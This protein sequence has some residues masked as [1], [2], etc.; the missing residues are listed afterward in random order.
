MWKELRNRWVAESPIFWQ[1]IL[2]FA[3]FLGSGAA[4]LISADAIWDFQGAGFPAII[5]V[6][7]KYAIAVATT[8]GLSAKITKQ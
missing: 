2:D 3:L 7:A 6:V 5:F 8:L 1:K 4:A